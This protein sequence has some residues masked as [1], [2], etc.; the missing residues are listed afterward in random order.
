MKKTWQKRRRNY[1]IDIL[2]FDILSLSLISI[3]LLLTSLIPYTYPIQDTNQVVKNENKD[4]NIYILTD[5]DLS[6]LYSYKQEEQRDNKEIVE[7]TYEEAQLLMYVGRAEAGDTLEGQK[8]VMRT[9]INRVQNERFPD[10]VYDVV[11]QKGQFEVVSSGS[12]KKVEINENT[13][14][15]LAAIESGWNETEGS[16]YWEATSNSDHSWHKKNLQYITTIEGNR[17]YK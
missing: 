17:Y 14:L 13:H 12:Y 7:L 1:W 16:L 11:Y 2:L 5:E 10:S 6:K 9:I 15:A 4:Y 3:L 8:W